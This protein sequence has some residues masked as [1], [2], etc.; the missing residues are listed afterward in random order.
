[1]G[2]NWLLPVGIEEDLPCRARVIEDMRRKVLDLFEVWGYDLVIPPLVEY[3]EALLV[4]KG[5]RLD[6]QTM[7]LIDQLNGKMM[8]IR[9]DMTPQVARIA[10]NR[11]PHDRIHRFCYLGSVLKARPEGALGSRQPLQFGAE[12]YGCNVLSADFEIIRMLLATLQRCG[13]RDITLSIGHIDVYRS[14]VKLAGL[15]ERQ[16]HELFVLLQRKSSHEIIRFLTAEGIGREKQSWFT[17]LVHFHGDAGVLETAL[18]YFSTYSTQVSQAIEQVKKIGIMLAEVS[19]AKVHFDLAELTGYQYRTGVC[20]AAYTPGIGQ[21]I[22]RGGRYND[23]TESFGV[24]LAAT[25]FS[26]D[27]HL[28]ATHVGGEREE[29]ETIFAP[30]CNES[31]LRESVAALRASGKRV[32]EQLFPEEKIRPEDYKS[33][34]LK[35]AGRWVVVDV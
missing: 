30:L 34:L 10:A 32:V 7:K 11:M 2:F 17:E 25:G 12:I 33:C 26:S 13:V 4:M 9:A 3:V 6:L 19:D 22:A 31:E 23:I 16:T 29:P 24:K 8:G 35:K 15:N 28:L 27:L 21:E 14:L 18:D 1:M 20:F 5:A